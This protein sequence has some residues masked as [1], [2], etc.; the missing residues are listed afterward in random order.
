M[1]SDKLVQLAS[2]ALLT[3]YSSII[4]IAQGRWPDKLVSLD[5]VG[6][7][8]AL[9]HRPRMQID[10]YQADPLFQRKH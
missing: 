5:K 1:S 3:P 6:N 9:I 2:S 10:S 8:D 7:G 4:S